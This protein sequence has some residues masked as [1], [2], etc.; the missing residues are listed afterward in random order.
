MSSKKKLQIAIGALIVTIGLTY[1]ENVPKECLYIVGI[2]VLLIL[3]VV[4][5]D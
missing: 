2:G 5:S 1:P 3:D 4:L